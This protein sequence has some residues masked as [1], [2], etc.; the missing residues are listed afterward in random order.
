M[1]LGGRLNGFPRLSLNARNVFF[2][3]PFFSRTVLTWDDCLCI[4]SLASCLFVTRTRS[5]FWCNVSIRLSRPLTDESRFSP[6]ASHSLAH[7]P[8]PSSPHFMRRK[9]EKRYQRAINQT[10]PSS[11][12]PQ[13]PPQSLI[14]MPRKFLRIED[15][16]GPIHIR[17]ER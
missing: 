9:R 13:Q 17:R 10:F 4:K 11:L 14:C 12:S 1:T 6:L 5:G 16:H 8:L 2:L 15:V 3:A 7:S